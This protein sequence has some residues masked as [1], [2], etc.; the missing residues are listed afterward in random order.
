MLSRLDSRAYSWYAVC[1]PPQ[2]EFVFQRLL[3]RDGFA[4]FVPTR[5][6]WRFANRIARVKK[7][8]SEK[9]YPVM[10]RYVFVGMNTGTPGWDAV[11]RFNII[12][13]TVIGFDGEPYQIPNDPLYRLM[14]EHNRGRFNA[15]D[16]HR[17]MQTHREFKAGDMVLTD[18][19]LF[20]GRVQ[21]LQGNM[22][23]VFIEMFGSSREVMVD[24]DKLVAA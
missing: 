17:Y 15:P 9:V 2:K 16:S 6:E 11:F 10:P 24:I 3:D 5:K 14:R 22:A 12:H 19:G 18:D 1:V 21:E 23:R 13:P 4:T 8:K 7:R 20:E